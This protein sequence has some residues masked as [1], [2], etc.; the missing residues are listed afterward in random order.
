MLSCRYQI[1]DEPGVLQAAAAE[2]ARRKAIGVSHKASVAQV[3]CVPAAG[4]PCLDDSAGALHQHGGRR[5]VYAR[6]MG[7]RVDQASRSGSSM[8]AQRIRLPGRVRGEWRH[9]V[10]L[11]YAVSTK[12]TTI[13]TG[14]AVEDQLKRVI[15]ELDRCYN[16]YL[17][18]KVVLP[19]PGG[20][21]SAAASLRVPAYSPY[22]GPGAAEVDATGHRQAVWVPQDPKYLQAIMN[23]V[24]VVTTELEDFPE[25]KQKVK[26]ILVEQFGSPSETLANEVWETPVEEQQAESSVPILLVREGRDNMKG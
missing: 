5:E 1:A 7:P 26:T 19:P 9:E 4:S 15:M 16:V 25:W 23:I 11:E 12:N 18:K 22:D 8:C 14:A 13:R 24:T 17:N 3:S 21:E 6:R 10:T 2:R 20:A